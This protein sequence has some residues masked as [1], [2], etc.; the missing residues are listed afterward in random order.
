MIQ[1]AG[2]KVA[3][4]GIVKSRGQC[5]WGGISL[6]RPSS[7]LNRIYMQKS[8]KIPMDLIATIP[9]ISKGYQHAAVWG[10]D[11]VFS[12]ATDFGGSDLYLASTSF[13]GNSNATTTISGTGSAENVSSVVGVVSGQDSLILCGNADC[14]LSDGEV[15]I[16]DKTLTQTATFTISTGLGDDGRV[17]AYAEDGG[18]LFYTSYTSPSFPTSIRRIDTNGNNDSQIIT[19]D[20]LVIRG[21]DIVNQKLYYRNFDGTTITVYRSDYDG[22]NTETLLATTGT[23]T[24]SGQ[25]EVQGG[26]SVVFSAWEQFGEYALF[27]RNDGINPN[28][29]ALN[30]DDIP[31]TFPVL[32]GFY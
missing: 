26:R 12:R 30:I 1:A 13:G 18:W 15:R 14:I 16:L 2:N 28:Y 29:G 6:F 10:G 22:T 9:G 17:S 32:Q 7:N 11:T 3:Q 23:D 5:A 31:G 20:R 21:V 27:F 4:S 24:L 19:G 25:G 8:S